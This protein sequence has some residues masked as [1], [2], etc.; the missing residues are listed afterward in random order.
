MAKKGNRKLYA[1]FILTIFSIIFATY[2]LMASAFALFAG[3]EYIDV[4]TSI[5]M[6]GYT[7]IALFTL[8]ALI[9]GMIITMI[10]AKVFLRPINELSTATQKVAGGD[11]S[12]RIN[13]VAASGTEVDELIVNFNKMVNDLQQI[14]TLKTDFIANVSHEFK[15]PLS[16]IQGYSTL[17][18]DETLTEDERRVYTQYIID[19]TKQLSSLIGNILKLSKLENR[20]CDLERT[21]FD[22][23]E[24]IRQSVLFMETQW[25]I[26]NIDLDIDLVSA[27]VEENEELLMQVWLNVIGN[28]IKFSDYAGK[29]IIRS[30]VHGR[31]FYKVT[32]QDYGCGMSEEALKRVFEKFYQGDNSHSKDGNG[33]GLALV[34]KILDFS[35]G[36]INVESV[37]GKGS[38]FTIYIPLAV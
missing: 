20:E 33:L 21:R 19:A 5:R 11:F 7:L 17:L 12:V 27:D 29:I 8:G 24:Q 23:A 14:E 32:V 28:A 37:E 1:K 35:G 15:T 10:A 6:D 31:D 34:K 16:T 18:Q 2:I 38:T 26:K 3:L 4:E 25:S 30:E 36:R 9:I 13:A 22:V